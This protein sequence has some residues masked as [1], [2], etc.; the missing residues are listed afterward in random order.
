MDDY[1]SENGYE[2]EQYTVRERRSNIIFYVV[3]ALVLVGII[4]FRVYWKNNFG[5]VIVDGQSMCQTLQDED[6]LLMRYVKDEKDFQRGDVIVVDVQKYHE[7]GSSAG[8]FLIK[9]LIAIEGDKVKCEDGQISIAYAGTSDYVLL[10]EP[11]AYYSNR[12]AYDFDEYVVGEGEVFFLGDNR[13]NSCDSRYQQSGGSHLDCL[14]KASDIYGV[15][16][17]WA[18]KNGKLLAKIFFW[19]FR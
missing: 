2:S 17:E 10:D 13:N 19:D 18:I 15:V 12:L 5:G 1:Q 14:Y 4:A 6:K 16:P 11:Y 7:E 9:R 3:I 8:N